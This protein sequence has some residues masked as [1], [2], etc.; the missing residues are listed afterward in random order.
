MAIAEKVKKS[1]VFKEVFSL[2]EAT[3]IKEIDK[4]QKE[5]LAFA[6]EE[7]KPLVSASVFSNFETILSQYT[8]KLEKAYS[9]YHSS[10]TTTDEKED[11]LIRLISTDR[12]AFTNA[13]KVMNESRK[14]RPRAPAPTPRKSKA[15]EPDKKPNWWK[16]MFLTAAG[17]GA[18]WFFTHKDN[19]QPSAPQEGD[20]VP[21]RMTQQAGSLNSRLN[22]GV[23]Q[24]GNTYVAES[25]QQTARRVWAESMNSSST[26]IPGDIHQGRII[27]QTQQLEEGQLNAANAELLART[28]GSLRRANDNVLGMS[29]D[30]NYTD[31]YNSDQ[32]LQTARNVRG[33]LHETSEMTLMTDRLK[34]ASGAIRGVS[35]MVKEAKDF[36]NMVVN[37]GPHR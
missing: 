4:W 30:K 6:E 15:K 10:S 20:K 2:M 26:P 32:Q 22:S 11:I 31:A 33:I 35:D 16:R 36:G 24:R 29:R 12:K 14:E 19:S 21:Q 23:V 27:R 1:A 9:E 7:Y 17:L 8:E 18:V 37:R 3:K 25:A 5:K 13:I 34:E 28:T